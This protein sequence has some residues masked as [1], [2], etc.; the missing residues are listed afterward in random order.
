MD[1]MGIIAFSTA[2]PLAGSALSFA[3]ITYSKYENL[4]ILRDLR[5]IFLDPV[6]SEEWG[7]SEQVERTFTPHSPLITLLQVLH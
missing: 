4:D 1:V 2:L 3:I 6:F 5:V 7:V